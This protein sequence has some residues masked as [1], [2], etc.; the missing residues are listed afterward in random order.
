MVEI[1]RETTEQDQNNHIYFETDRED[2]KASTIR[3]EV[4]EI[5]DIS[6]KLYGLQWEYIQGMEITYYL[7]IC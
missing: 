4:L 2:I 1:D 3:Y 7:Y 5:A 6:Y